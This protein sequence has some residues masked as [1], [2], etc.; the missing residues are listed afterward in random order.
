MENDLHY[1]TVGPLTDYKELLAHKGYEV[2]GEMCKV[3]FK[4]MPNQPIPNMSQEAYEELGDLVQGWIRQTMREYFG[5][6]E[7]WIGGVGN[8]PKSN[9]YVSEDFTTNKEKCMV[10]IQGTGPCR[11][12]VWARSV[13]INEGINLGSIFPQLEHART[14]GYSVIVLNPN[15]AVDPISGAKV[16]HC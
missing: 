12:G 1:C 3:H 10:F 4:G 6:K 9:I 5:L 8:S 2:S 11:P 13:C 16:P 15:F 7:L 14:H